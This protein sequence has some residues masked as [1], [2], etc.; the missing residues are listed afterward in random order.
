M[1]K[2]IKI[3]QK[4][5]SV[6]G[7]EIVSHI[8]QLKYIRDD[9]YTRRIFNKKA[10]CIDG[11]NF[12]D[13]KKKVCNYLLSMQVKNYEYRFSEKTN[14]PTLY[15]SVYACMIK[16]LF[17][18]IKESEKAD[19]VEYFDSFQNDDGLFIDPVCLNETY[20]QGDGWGARHLVPHIIIAY[21][22]LGGTPKKEFLFLKKL[23]DPDKM[24]KWISSLDYRKVW[25]SSNA[26][27][28][29]GVTMQ[30]ARDYMG[31]ASGKAI[32][33]MQNWLLKHARKDCGMWFEGSLEKKYNRYQAIRGAYH[34][35][36]ILIYDGIDL[37]YAD[38][39]LDFIMKSQNKWG[40]FDCHIGSSACDDIDAIDPMIRL[41][42]QL[43]L[44]KDIIRPSLEKAFS[45]V[46]VNQNDDGGFVFRRRGKFSYGGLKQLSSESQQSN[47]F[48]TWFRT[49]SILYILEYLNK[50]KTEFVR[51]PGYEM[52][53]SCNL[54]KI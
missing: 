42:I 26:I 41:A 7:E 38:K 9:L 4:I 52:P 48:A 39:A 47:M 43:N 23:L 3:K 35:Y 34:I 49:L 11:F 18:I 12:N 50:A 28:N 22:R 1:R 51:I 19:W 16:G 15:S 13:F 14:E 25:S 36:P 20:M 2:I 32:E 54:S 6:L 17:G 45:W 44:S 8:V 5:K 24:L 27:M 53:I 46:L 40:G 33:A 29:Y 21:N 31:L 10:L 37:P 30:Y